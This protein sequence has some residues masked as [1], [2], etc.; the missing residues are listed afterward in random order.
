MTAGTYEYRRGN[1]KRM[2]RSF[3]CLMAAG[4]VGGIGRGPDGNPDIT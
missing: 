4:S 2:R 1:F 3:H